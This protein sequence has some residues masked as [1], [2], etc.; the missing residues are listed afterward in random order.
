M[1]KKELHKIAPTLSELSLKK[2]GFNVPNSYFNSIEDSVFAEIIASEINTEKPDFKTPEHYFNTLED[3]VITKLNTQNLQLENNN[4]V[5]ENYFNTLEDRV[6]DRLNKKPKVTKL[7]SIT[8]YIA[9]IAIA[10][11][12]L[13]IF[14]LNN[15]SR[16]ITFESIASAEIEEFIDLGHID[17]D[18]ESLTTVFPDIELD[19]NNFISSLS[20]N[21]V[22]E[23]LNENDLEELFYEN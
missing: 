17:Y 3:I 8:K 1:N 10:A 18:A 12:F 7:K 23:Y 16:E 6:I 20:E 4:T 5:P 13:I 9:P 11:S 21:D 14:L 19:D 22:L 15:N 2:S